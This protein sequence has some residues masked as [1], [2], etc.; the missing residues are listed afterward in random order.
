MRNFQ[1]QRQVPLG[2]ISGDG[3]PHL[4]SVHT[5][6]L[7][8]LLLLDPLQFSRP[9]PAV[10]PRHLQYRRNHASHRKERCSVD[11]FSHLPSTG[12]Y[13]NSDMRHSG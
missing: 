11:F 13:D 5:S 2:T 10:A 4:R 12:P 1:D 7:R 3:C 9:V 8:L 6:F